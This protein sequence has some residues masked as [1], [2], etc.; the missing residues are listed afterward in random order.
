MAGPGGSGG[1]AGPGGSGGAG[2]T[3]GAG[4]KG[5]LALCVPGECAAGLECRALVKGGASRC[6]SSCTNNTT[7]PQGGRC[8]ND[9]TGGRC[10]GHDTGR[11][12][13]GP[14]DC[15]FACITGPDYCT[16]ECIDGS[17]CPNG[18]GCM[19]VSNIDV[20]VKLEAPCDGAANEQ[21]VVQAACDTTDPNLIIWGC[22]SVCDTDQ[23]CPQRALPLNA[24]PWTCDPGGICRRPADVYGPFPGGSVPTEWHCDALQQGVNLCSDAQHIDFVGFTIPPPPAG[25][26]CASQFTTTGAANDACVNSCRFQGDCP[27]TYSCVAVGSVAGQRIGLCLPNGTAEPGLPCTNNTQCAFGYCSNNVCSR[28]CTADGLCPGGLSC[29]AAGGP[30]VEGLPFRRCE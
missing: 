17:D 29:V 18:Y 23:D 15:N 10:L 8:I 19:P 20:C 1:L 22:T 24:N 27:Y 16:N 25:I 12:C 4:Q 7:C 13:A 11:T 5:E 28:D 9:G 26:D 21:C 14:N 30:P 3:G 2:G 6:V